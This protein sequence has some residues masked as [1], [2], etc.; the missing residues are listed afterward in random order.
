MWGI[1]VRLA[2]HLNMKHAM[3]LVFIKLELTRHFTLL[4]I[5]TTD[6]G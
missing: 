3:Q 5:T 6:A 2:C 1:V 4:T